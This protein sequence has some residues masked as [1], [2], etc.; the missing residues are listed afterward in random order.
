MVYVNSFG[1]R[2]GVPNDSDLV[3]DVPLPA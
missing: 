1:Y 3:F 2:Y